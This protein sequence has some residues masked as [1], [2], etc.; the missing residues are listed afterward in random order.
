[1]NYDEMA[2]MQGLSV[3]VDFLEKWK[4]YLA[5]C[6]RSQ[7]AVI[8]D[9]VENCDEYLSDPYVPPKDDLKRKMKVTMGLS[10]RVKDKI[11]LHEISDPSEIGLNIKNILNAYMN[12][13]PVIGE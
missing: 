9:A 10:M 1:M 5:A 3:E 13:N 7:K 8:A 12:K 2:C 11:K 4:K 6:S